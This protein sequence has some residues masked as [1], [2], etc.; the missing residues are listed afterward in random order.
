MV[1]YTVLPSLW[2]ALLVYRVIHDNQV[3]VEGLAV[4]KPCILYLLA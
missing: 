2:N 4:L 1:L 3:Q